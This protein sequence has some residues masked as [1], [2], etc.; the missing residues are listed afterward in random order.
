MYD[1]EFKRDAE[2]SYSGKGLFYPD[3]L[4]EPKLEAFNARYVHTV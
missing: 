4:L 1:L 2:H 3:G